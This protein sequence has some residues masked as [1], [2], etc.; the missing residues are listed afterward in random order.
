MDTSPDEELYKSFAYLRD[1]IRVTSD[2]PDSHVPTLP[3]GYRLMA[4]SSVSR[5]NLL[6]LPLELREDVYSRVFFCRLS[7]AFFNPAQRGQQRCQ[8][9]RHGLTLVCRSVRSEVLAHFYRTHEVHF[10]LSANDKPALLA[11]LSNVDVD[12]LAMIQRFRI[13]SK[14]PC[15]LGHRPRLVKAKVSAQQQV[16]S[17]H[18]CCK[19]TRLDM[20]WRLEEIL[21]TLPRS[22][23][24]V[25]LTKNGLRDMFEV[26]GWFQGCYDLL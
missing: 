11:W 2:H 19:I 24:R 21:E 13:K 4:S 22:H 26:V 7:T 10:I 3:P 15:R 23:G 14:E 5:L 18:S 25:V 17:A 16:L 8:C 12:E 20:Q 9:M 6:D 1:E